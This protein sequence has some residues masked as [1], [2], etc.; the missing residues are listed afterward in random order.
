MK[1]NRVAP[2][3]RQLEGESAVP[4]AEILTLLQRAPAR[5]LSGREILDSFPL[6][7][8]D[9][10]QATLRA[11]D[12]WVG[13]EILDQRKDRRY[14]FPWNKRLVIGPIRVQRGGYGFVS[15]AEGSD[16]IFVAARNLAGALDGDR[17][18]TLVEKRRGRDDAR[19]DGRIISIVERSRAEMLGR[20][21]AGT[22]SGRLLPIIPRFAP[23]LLIAKEDENGILPGQ[24]GIARISS[25]ISPSGALSGTITEILGAADDPSVDVATIA[26]KYHLPTTF[27][28]AVMRSANAIPSEVL[29]TEISGRVDLRDLGLVTIDGASA[30]DFDD[31]VAVRREADGQ[32][33]L[34]VA[35]ADVSHYVRPGD[36]IDRE[37]LQRGTSVY[38]PDRA[39]PMLP[40]HLS[41][42]I[43]SLQAEI[44]RLAVVAEILFSPQGERLTSSFY[45]AVIRSRARL[46]Y[47]QVYAWLTDADARA[48][49]PDDLLAQTAVMVELSAQLTAMRTARGSIDFDLPEAE[50]VVNLRGKPEDI[51]RRERNEVHKLIEEFMLAANEAVADFLTEKEIPLLYRIH[52]EPELEKMLE[53]QEFT[54]PLG[55]GFAGSTEK[56]L[57]RALQELL[58]A[59]A[60]APE[61]RAIHQ[62][63]LRSMKQARYAAENAGHFGLAASRY[64]HFTSPIR[65][66]PDLVVHR[67]LCQL[68]ETATGIDSRQRLEWQKE[69]LPLGEGLSKLERRATDAE[70]EMVNL[71]KC[72]F[73][74]DKIGEEFDGTVS[75]VQ[76]YGLF[77]ELDQWFVEGLVAIAA[78]TDDF[79][80]FDPLHQT[81]TGQRRRKIWRVGEALR[82]KV[83]R[84]N[85]DWREIDFAPVDMPA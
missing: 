33:R 2:R 31:A 58:A 44:D 45:R 73:M 52:E 67:V 60:E 59:T 21:V 46:T 39:L 19:P 61:G 82:V 3:H 5:S 42:G 76:S 56:S 80:E 65:R 36:E 18:A 30:R 79:Y 74:A 27:P 10:R 4:M 8:R 9:A 23:P 75:G 51:I 78:L 63:V 1:R 41:N 69:F 35:I 26:Y 71:Y 15:G 70:R 37:A 83:L 40:E 72:R 66:Y 68:L 48:D 57:P 11:L 12:R 16:D 43:C 28:E 13:E 84:V 62:L 25:K 32:T 17:V 6:L 55:Y 81:L 53:L 54:A 50:I 20:F 85:P 29:P 14:T 47:D 38:F 24:I 34:W 7:D 49:A 64:C 77:V 22:P